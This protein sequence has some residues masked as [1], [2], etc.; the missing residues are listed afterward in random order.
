MLGRVP[1]GE[2]LELREAGGHGGEAWKEPEDWHYPG[3]RNRWRGLHGNSGMV[4]EN[5]AVAV[6][7]RNQRMS[8]TPWCCLNTNE[9]SPRY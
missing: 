2:D 7:E 6:N 5:R 8:Q 3:R 9:S 4:N 1:D